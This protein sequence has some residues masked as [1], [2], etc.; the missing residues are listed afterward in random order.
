MLT[1]I[2]PLIPLSVLPFLYRGGA[3]D[4]FWAH[5][6][7][8]LYVAWLLINSL[9]RNALS[10][11][12]RVTVPVV[13]LSYAINSDALSPE[14]GGVLGIIWLLFMAVLLMMVRPTR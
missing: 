7:A 14:T 9:P 1:L 10:L 11:V 13:L 12:L 4:D 2:G 8:L 6:I 5:F 3:L